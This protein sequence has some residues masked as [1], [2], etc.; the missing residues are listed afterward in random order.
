MRLYEPAWNKCKA[1]GSVTIR[2]LPIGG[3]TTTSY[4]HRIV[5]MLEK[6]KYRDAGF[7]FEC[8]E[9][10]VE[11]RMFHYLEERDGKKYLRFE[12]KYFSGLSE[13]DAT[14]IINSKLFC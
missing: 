2:L 13:S 11:A 14:A 8:A 12:L 5:R 6:E 7:K 9:K 10:C 4:A 3:E 1:E